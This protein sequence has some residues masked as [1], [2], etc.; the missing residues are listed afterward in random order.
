MT[1]KQL[2]TVSQQIVGTLRMLN[3]SIYRDLDPRQDVEIYEFFRPLFHLS[4][5]K[6]FDFQFIWIMGLLCIVDLNTYGIEL[7]YSIHCCFTFPELHFG[8]SFLSCNP[9]G[10]RIYHIS[11]SAGWV[12]SRM[13]ALRILCTASA[14]FLLEFN[15][16]PLRLRA[17]G[18]PGHPGQQVSHGMGFIVLNY[19]PS[20]GRCMR[21]GTF[22]LYPLLCSCVYE[23]CKNIPE[24]PPV[25]PH[26]PFSPTTLDSLGGG[27]SVNVWINKLYASGPKFPRV[28][29]AYE[30]FKC[31]FGALIKIKLI[32]CVCGALIRP[33]SV[34]ADGNQGM[35]PMRNRDSVVIC[36]Q[37]LKNTAERKSSCVHRIYVA[38]F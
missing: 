5:P 34:Y 18:H 15:T 32:N 13:N 1:A 28:A 8:I 37:T 9:F 35:S 7:K 3:S 16:I 19:T 21:V 11:S 31:N 23:N 24:P 6:F 2:A 4:V 33:Y 22:F 25:F 38:Y 26:F 12:F 17:P 36:A 29:V 30:I 14:E 10:R 27:Q 20:A